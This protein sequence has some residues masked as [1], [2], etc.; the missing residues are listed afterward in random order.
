MTNGT[1]I[2][3]GATSGYVNLPGGLVS[4][5][6]AVTLEFWA[7]FGANGNWAR[8]FD[9]GNIS[10]GSGL[11]YFYFS[12][13]NGSSGQTMEV[14]TNTTTTFAVP[15]TLDG[16][17]V[18]VV[19]ILDPTNNYAAIYTNGVLEATLLSRW[20]GFGSVSR[21]W[22]FIGRSLFTGDAY[23]TA[24][25]DELR[26]YDGRL[27]PQEIT[28]DYQFGPN[29]L[30]LAVNLVQSNSVANVILSWPSW[31][32]GFALQSSS[33]LI[34]WSTNGLTPALANDIWS[35]AIPKTNAATFYRL[36]R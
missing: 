32:V 1:L 36:Q 8:V 14:R 19:C 31:A 18:H 26:L 6:S 4:G 2:L 11:D 25:I 20:P 15:G 10:G 33:N 30:A 23:L 22:S 3:N 17:S 29:A 34:G 7:T 35:L 12:P 5:S 13:H 16:R 24:T 21:A 27:T 28:T 9:S